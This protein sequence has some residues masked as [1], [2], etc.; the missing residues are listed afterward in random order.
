MGIIIGVCLSGF[1]IVFVV[2]LAL[3]LV[4][5]CVVVGRAKSKKANQ[6][7]KRGQEILSTG[8]DQTELSNN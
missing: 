7:R 6:R 4:I 5:L 8:Y 2:P 3:C 1:V